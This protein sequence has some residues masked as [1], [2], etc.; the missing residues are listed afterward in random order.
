[1]AGKAIFVLES[2]DTPVIT[3][4]DRP[5][6]STQNM[7]AFADVL[8]GRGAGVRLVPLVGDDVDTAATMG[9]MV[10]T[11]MAALAQMGLEIAPERIID[12]VADRRAAGK[13][14]DGRRHIVADSQIRS[15]L[16]WIGGGEPVHGVMRRWS[17]MRWP[18][19]GDEGGAAEL[20]RARPLE[21]VARALARSAR[22][23]WVCRR[24]I[25]GA[26]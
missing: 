3:T 8:R 24:V 2:S 14:P 22:R 10:F 19:G 20:I 12:S 9:S 16:R 5:G 15:F 11:V 17:E 23:P 26:Q 6:R 13:G 18:T 25:T 4:V 21:R 1:M 7:L